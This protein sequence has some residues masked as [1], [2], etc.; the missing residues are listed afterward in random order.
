[1]TSKTTNIRKDEADAPAHRSFIVQAKQVTQLSDYDVLT[2]R[3]FRL[4]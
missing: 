2:Y 3:L 1:M 4:I